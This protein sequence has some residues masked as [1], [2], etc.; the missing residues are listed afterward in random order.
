MGKYIFLILF[1]GT[2]LGGG[3]L[4]AFF[5]SPDTR[6]EATNIEGLPGQQYVEFAGLYP[7]TEV[8]VTGT[9]RDNPTLSGDRVADY[10]L[11]AYEIEEWDVSTDTDGNVSS[12]W[13]SISRNIPILT[14]QFEDAMLPIH[15]EQQQPQLSGDL[16][17]FIEEASGSFGRSSAQYDGQ[18][19]Y[20]GSLRIQGLRNN[21]LVT[22][23]GDKADDGGVVPDRIHSGTHTDLINEL[24]QQAQIMQI[25]GGIFAVIGAVVLIGT[26]VYALK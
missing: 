9:L 24:R 3:L 2:F 16:H 8:A 26:A 5:V 21:D 15:A 13:V 12:K 23:I 22:V 1:G 6:E 11:V 25:G 18:G 7:G 10:E 19:L 4:L 14:I 20:E 17:E